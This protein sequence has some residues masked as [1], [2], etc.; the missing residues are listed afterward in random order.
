INRFLTDDLLARASPDREGAQVTVLEL[1]HR[2]SRA[3]DARFP[4]RPLVAASIHQALGDAYA[5]LG[6]QDDAEHHIDQGIEL[7][8]AVAGPD[9]PD[10]VRSEISRA[11][12]IARRE[13]Y[14][15]AEEPLR[16]AVARAR[17]LLGAEDRDLYTALNDLGVTLESL[18]RAGEALP[19]LEE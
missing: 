1:L 19:A 13:L 7:R 18:G 15:E 10:T 11:S 8:R 12:L 14:A 6:D 3:I 17:A 2:A 9:A 5:E 4:S 16:N